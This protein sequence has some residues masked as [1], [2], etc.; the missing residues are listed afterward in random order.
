[1]YFK[2][3]SFFKSNETSFVIFFYCIYAVF[4]ILSTLSSWIRH[5]P[6]G[7][8]CDDVTIRYPYRTDTVTLKMLMLFVFFIPLVVVSEI[9]WWHL[10]AAPRIRRLG[11][12]GQCIWRCEGVNK[13]KTL[14]FERKK[15]RV[16][17]PPAPMVS[18]LLNWHLS[19]LLSEQFSFK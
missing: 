11:G 17:D 7:F 12:G 2:L 3:H 1:M 5:T 6:R 9:T 15:V 13:V 19:C 18:P 4:V 8:F 14:T 10:R 16:H